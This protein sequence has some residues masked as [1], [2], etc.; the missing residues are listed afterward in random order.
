M[1]KLQK[2][3]EKVFAEIAETSQKKGA[4]TTFLDIDKILGLPESIELKGFK[5]EYLELVTDHKE[6]ISTLAS[7]EEIII[8]IRCKSMIHSELRLS[9][10]RNYI[11]ARSI[12]YRRGTKIND[13]RV[14]V[15]TT[16][17]FGDNLGKL[18]Y[19]TNFKTLCREK[20]LI[21]MEKE[22]KNNINQLKTLTKV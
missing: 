6:V 5:D 9:L 16:E 15:G 17:K 13:I 8:Q 22:I 12:F 10:S 11:Y 21:T 20:L 3:S 7:I 1:P 18:A 4:Y 19:D 2:V 14:P